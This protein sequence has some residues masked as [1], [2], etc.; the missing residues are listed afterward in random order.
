[1][2][3]SAPN[4][5]W[6]VAMSPEDEREMLKKSSSRIVKLAFSSIQVMSGRGVAW[7]E[8]LRVTKSPMVTVTSCGSRTKVGGAKCV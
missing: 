5:N 3:A 8:Q 4:V 2:P 7:A 6:L 1:M